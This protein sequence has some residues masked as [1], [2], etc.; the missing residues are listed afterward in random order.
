M[1]GKRIQARLAGPA[2]L[3]FHILHAVVHLPTD[4][5]RRTEE[6]IRGHS[7]V[8]QRVQRSDTTVF[9]PG[10]LRQ[11][12]YDQ[13]VESIHGDTVAR[14]NRGFRVG[15]YSRQRRERSIDAPNYRQ[16]RVMLAGDSEHEGHLLLKLKRIHEYSS[17][18]VP[19]RT[20]H[21]E[22]VTIHGNNGNYH[23]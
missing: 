5:R 4:T 2:P 21:D 3:S 17:M 10:L 22:T 15:H 20:L 18:K 23:V 7:G 13:M 14:F 11:Y 19:C 12:R 16:V 6:D 1:A 8:L 9:R